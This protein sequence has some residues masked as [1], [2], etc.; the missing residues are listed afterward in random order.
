MN[1]NNIP[2]II[3]HFCI[4]LN[5]MRMNICT[6]LTA[7][8]P[9]QMKTTKNFGMYVG[10]RWLAKVAEKFIGRTIYRLRRRNL[11]NQKNPHGN[12]HMVAFPTRATNTNGVVAVAAAAATISVM[13]VTTSI[14]AVDAT[15]TVTSTT[16]QTTSMETTHHEIACS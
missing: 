8:Y 14:V 6:K 11:I 7:F 3:G 2:V 9:L 10:K 12:S 4:K 1:L 15:I 16:T 13:V 5:W